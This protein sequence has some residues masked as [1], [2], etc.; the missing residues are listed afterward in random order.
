MYRYAVAVLCFLGTLVFQTEG[1]KSSVEPISVPS[2]TVLTF[3]LQ[4]RLNP[5]S[6]NEMDV[7][8]RGTVLKVKMLD[9]IDSAVDRDGSQFRGEVVS[10]VMSGNEMVL[11]SDAEVR[12]LLALLRSR[13]HP[14]GFRYELLITKVS[15][16]GRSYD[17][18]AS[19]NASFA[20]TVPTQASV[21]SD[22]LK[23]MK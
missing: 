9:G 20:D 1:Q 5:G 11:H 19:L 4:T 23:N 7:L 12:G 13:N 15:D 3:F 14:E 16:H 6:G 21:K 8:P 10:P 18:T 2:G 22:G 17:L